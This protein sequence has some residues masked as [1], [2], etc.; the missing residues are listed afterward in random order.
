[1]P[2]SASPVR[3]QAELMQ[4]ASMAGQRQHRSAAEQIEYWASI[5]RS[6]S[7]IINQDTLLEF[8]AGLVRLKIEPVESAAIAPEEV[9]SDLES[10]RKSGRLVE[11]VTTSSVRYQVSVRHPGQLEQILADG[12][13]I[14]GQFHDGVFTPLPEAVD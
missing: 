13:V 9:F 11:S 4:S 14:V 10:D 6:V 8:S 7:K 2:K 3:L 1:M 12:R 5:G